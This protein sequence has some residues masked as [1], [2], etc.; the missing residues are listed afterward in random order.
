MIP[1]RTGQPSDGRFDRAVDRQR[2]VVERLIKR[3][4]W[5]RPIATRYEKRAVGYRA[6][7]PVA[8][9]LLWL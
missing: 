6:M 4:K 8:A 5:W 3:L 2:N 1:T 9:I 7:V